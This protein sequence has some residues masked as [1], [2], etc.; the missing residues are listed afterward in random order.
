MTSM[1]I[2]VATGYYIILNTQNEIEGDFALSYWYD[3]KAV[4]HVEAQL[5]GIKKWNTATQ[6]LTSNII[7]GRMSE[8]TFSRFYPK[9][10]FEEATPQVP[11][12]TWSDLTRIQSERDTNDYLNAKYVTAVELC[13]NDKF[14]ALSDGKRK[15]LL[16]SLDNYASQYFS[17]LVESVLLE[18]PLAKTDC[19]LLVY[20][21][22]LLEFTNYMSMLNES[23]EISNFLEGGFSKITICNMATKAQLESPQTM[24][25]KS[26]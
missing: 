12:Y 4:T 1:E 15:S 5:V 14:Y 23:H 18:T 24:T 19:T 9:T 3:D 11:G 20:F 22:Q 16:T 6:L 17:G 13:F 21:D 25:P 10:P 7:R 2:Q 8:I 26:R